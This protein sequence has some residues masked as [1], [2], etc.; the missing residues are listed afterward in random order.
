MGAALSATLC[1]PATGWASSAHASAASARRLLILQSGSVTDAGF[2]SGVAARSG[3]ATV[4]SLDLNQLLST[5]IASSA[6]ALGPLRGRRVLGLIDAPRYAMFQEVLRELGAGIWAEGHHSA[7][8]TPVHRF[9]PL[10]RSEGAGARLSALLAQASTPR[11]WVAATGAL[12]AG[13]AL[14]PDVQGGITMALPPSIDASQAASAIGA[15]HISF[16]ADL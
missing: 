3:T 6:K 9:T 16:V 1:L 4:S 13:I 8:D 12:M 15:P 2:M 14:R 7:D 11:S 10:P 5:G